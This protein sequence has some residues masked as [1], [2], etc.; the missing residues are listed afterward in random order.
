MGQAFPDVSLV[1]EEE[2]EE[3]NLPDELDD[4]G[5]DSIPKSLAT[6]MN[7]QT[8]NNLMSP[9]RLIDSNRE[10]ASREHAPRELISMYNSQ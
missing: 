10:Y 1:D 8:L 5:K 4:T 7:N 9:S 6:T 3:Y 2:D